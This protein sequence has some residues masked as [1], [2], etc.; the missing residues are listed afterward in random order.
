MRNYFDVIRRVGDHCVL[1]AALSLP[2]LLGGCADGNE[3]TPLVEPD[4]P[5]LT[6]TP[7]SVKTL[8]FTWSD[9]GA[10][11]EYR[12]LVNPDG[13]SGYSE[14]A[15][16]NGSRT[17]YDQTVFLPRRLDASYML[18]ACN[19]S[20]CA[21]SDAVYV[22]TDLSQAIGYLKASNPDVNDY[23]GNGIALSANGD[24]L[25]VGAPGEEGDA[26]AIS[27]AG[28]V[29][30]FHRDDSGAWS[31]QALLRASNSGQFDQFGKN[32]T[33]NTSGDVL[34]V[35]AIRESSDATGINNDGTN[36]NADKSGAAY[37]FR[38][39]TAGNWQQ[40]AYL[41]ASN[42][43]AGDYFGFS[44]ALTGDGTTLA[45]GAPFED[46][47]ATG[48][49]GDQNN[50][51]ATQSGAVYTFAHDGNAWAQTAYLKASNTGGG[52]QFGNS[53][54][55]SGDG[56]TLA[57]GAFAEASGAT[58]INGDQN[59]NTAAT[60]GAVYLFG[61]D[62][63]GWVQNTYLKAS[64]T[65]SADNFGRSVALDEDGD[66][67]AVGAN[68]EDSAASSIGGAQNDNAAVSSGAAYLFRNDGGWTQQAYIKASNA[69]AGDAF[70]FKLALT[71]DGNTLAVSA[72][73]EQSAS[74]GLDGDAS[75][76]N[77]DSSG[78][79]Y[80]FDWR[81]G[82]WQQSHYLKANNTQTDDFFGFSLA[83]A[84]D[85]GTLA[86]GAYHEDGSAT[87]VGGNEDNATQNA[88]AVYLY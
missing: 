38:R 40:E 54:A 35:G 24:T 58:G 51:A 31:Q 46:S 21:T 45:V 57:I 11:S 67:L 42:T 72:S 23:F 53:L 81:G 28:A 30:I 70:G 84:V 68:Q 27:Y 29:Y 61:P 62:G 74:T 77:A 85:G 20:G 71:G 43:T 10:A 80:L 33:L 4:Q 19:N 25:A 82:A 64:N 86:V 66:T 63:S 88:G 2:L 32:L 37:V 73:N 47:D 16:F 8:S 69:G 34:A 15:R 44:L 39:D 36:D 48:S 26:N 3:R 55:F 41:K 9:N 52:D 56:D 5:A 79:V 18:E 13:A 76:N 17:H 1:S 83:L 60:A 49:G 87:G 59:D 6:L 12:L 22:N 75:D 7:T 14:A 78:A 50:D 65:E